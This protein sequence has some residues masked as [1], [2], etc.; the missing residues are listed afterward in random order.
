VNAKYI[1]VPHRCNNDI[2]NASSRLKVAQVRVDISTDSY[3]KM[4][5]Q[6][7]RKRRRRKSTDSASPEALLRK[8]TISPEWGDC[9]L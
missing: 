9:F 1:F 6:Q 7:K 5:W 3:L 4:I 8:K 2:E